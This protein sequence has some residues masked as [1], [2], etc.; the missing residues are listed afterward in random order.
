M[1][2]VGEYR[3]GRRYLDR[4]HGSWEEQEPRSGGSVVLPDY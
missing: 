3:T 4:T 2:V 1:V